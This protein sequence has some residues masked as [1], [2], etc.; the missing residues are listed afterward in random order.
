MKRRRTA[1]VFIL[2][3]GTLLPWRLAAWDGAFFDLFQ[4]PFS[5]REAALGGVHAALAD[6][7]TT[8]VSNP[9]GFRSAGPEF[10]LAE[11]TFSIYDSAPSLLDEVITS[12]PSTTPDLRR[13]TMN[14]MGPLFIGYVGDGLGFGLFSSTNVRTWTW[15][16]YP[17]GRSVI[18]QNLVVVAGYSFRIPFPEEWQSTL[19]LG[20]TIPVFVTARSD[21]AKDVRGIFT[22][23]I[24]PPAV[25]ADQ[26]FTMAEGVSA[27]FGILYSYDN[28]FS[29]GI[30]ARDLAIVSTNSYPS[31]VSFLAGGLPDT[32]N[33][34]LPM[35]ISAGFKWSPPIKNL[36]RS[37]DG[38]SLMADYH[39][40]FDF[41]FYP[42]GARNPFLHIG[43]GLEMQILQIVKLRAGFYQ[44]LPSG[45]IELDLS[46]FKLN[47]AVFGRELTS[48]PWGYPV[49]GYMIGVRF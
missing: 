32:R 36:L 38:L 11:M 10:S 23:S 37:I 19:D 35:D 6:D 28:V 22:S 39:D 25:V 46:L 7:L 17:A 42:E 24:T 21:T 29:V 2:T 13:A 8:L 1:F 44:C 27:E 31:L 16:A 49:Y 5:A 20:F 40:I 18:Q 43:I 45:G 41:V 48:R 26:P 14:L 4:I 3:L 47:V 9:A 34:P 15:G 33:T 30:A 12:Q